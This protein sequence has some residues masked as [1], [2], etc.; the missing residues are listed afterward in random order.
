[1]GHHQ[2]HPDTGADGRE[3]DEEVSVSEQQDRAQN[4]IVWE[5]DVQQQNP[6]IVKRIEEG[7][8]RREIKEKRRVEESR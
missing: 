8:R 3:T 5:Q 6:L 4:G 2:G 1:M 7:E